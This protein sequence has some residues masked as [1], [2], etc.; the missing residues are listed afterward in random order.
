[1]TVNCIGNTLLQ[2][3][4]ILTQL[5][6]VKITISFFFS[7]MFILIRLFFSFHDIN[8]VHYLALL[9]IPDLATGNRLPYFN[10]TYLLTH[11]ILFL[12]FTY[13]SYDVHSRQLKESGP[14][15]L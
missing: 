3:M 15:H 1:M 13:F 10:F 9:I 5:L 12:L 7:D 4:D 14:I 11:F 8:T 6:Q 2:G